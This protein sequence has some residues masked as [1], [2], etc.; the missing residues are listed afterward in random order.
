MTGHRAAAEAA[1]VDRLRKGIIDGD[2]LPETDVTAL[3]AFYSALS[4]GLA[5]QARDGATSEKLLSI[6]R[7]AMRA[8]PD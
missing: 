2:L 1:M 7:S 4:R 8:W 6:A 5:V 3:A